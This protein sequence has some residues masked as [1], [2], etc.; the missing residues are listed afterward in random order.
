MSYLAAPATVH[1]L[2]DALRHLLRDVAGWQ[3]WTIHAVTHGEVAAMGPIPGGGVARVHVFCREA[4]KRLEPVQLASDLADQS[5]TL[6]LA[7]PSIPLRVR[8]WCEKRGWGWFDLLGNCY[9]PVPGAAPL[10][11]TAALSAPAPARKLQPGSASRQL[12]A[13]TGCAVTR[14]LLAPENAGRRWTQ[15][16]IREHLGTSAPSVGMTNRLTQHLRE[17][18]HLQPLRERGFRVTDTE[19][20]LGVWCG[21]LRA[22]KRPAARIRRYRCDLPETVLATCFTG[23]AALCLFSAARRHAAAL[24]AA[25]P[26]CLYVSPE[27]SDARLVAA[28]ARPVHSGE[29]LRLITA[30]DPGVFYALHV[31][32]AGSLPSTSLLQTYVDLQLAGPGDECAQSAAAGLLQLLRAAWRNNFQAES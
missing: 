15:A 11:H 6:V 28:G 12:A 20:L 24:T 17:R 16:S 5:S 4:V 19:T 10:E 25:S 8:S 7:S 31:G 23:Q 14:A 29:N 18:G 32:P 30:E 27:V 22:R 21:A 9:L 3:G 2:G 1:E 13:P 26:T